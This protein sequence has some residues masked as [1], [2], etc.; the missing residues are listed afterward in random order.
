MHN[1]IK[2]NIQRY[3][4][5]QNDTS[6]YQQRMGEATE[7]GYSA[8]DMNLESMGDFQQATF[9]IDQ[10]QSLKQDPFL[11][12]SRNGNAIQSNQLS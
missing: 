9:S 12:N 11:Q 5:S 10:N 2:S 3:M 7:S 1:N 4:G 8:S 6:E